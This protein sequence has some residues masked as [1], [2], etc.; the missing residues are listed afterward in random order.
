MKRYLIC[1]FNMRWERKYLDII[2][3]CGADGEICG[4]ENK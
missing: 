4:K 1:I 2:A 3:I